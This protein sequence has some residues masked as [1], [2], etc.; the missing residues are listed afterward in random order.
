V[1]RK[2]IKTIYEECRLR[3]PASSELGHQWAYLRRFLPK[4]K[5][6]R[7]LD[8]GCGNGR[9]AFALVDQGYS[10]VDGIDL[11]DQIETLGAF[12]Y[13]CGSIDRIEF[14]DETFDFV[15]SL[16]VLYYLPDPRDGLS[17][18]WRVLKPGGTLVLSSHTRYSLF[19][20]V[21]VLRVKSGLAKHLH[22]VRFRS[23]DAYCHMLDETGF[24]IVD[25]DGFRLIPARMIDRFIGQN[26]EETN[27]RRYDRYF[28]KSG[29]WM[30][31]FRSRAGYHFIIAARKPG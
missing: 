11:F 19:T 29:S 8:A 15:Y 27:N 16:S 23:A 1:E 21:R 7:I 4:A 14:S 2:E 28:S 31:S 5:H 12:R 9:Y 17:E 18:M 24:R 10:Q 26:P 22:G 20:L 6:S 3:Q 13:K 25:V 30:K